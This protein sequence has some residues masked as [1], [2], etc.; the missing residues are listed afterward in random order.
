VYAYGKP[1][2]DRTHEI[3]VFG[4]WQIPKIEVGLNAYYRYMSGRTWTAFQ[5]FSGSAINWPGFGS[6]GRQPWL[7][8]RGSRRL[9]AESY[10][11]LRLEKI[12]NLGAGTDRIAVYADVQNLL[13]A[14][15][16]IATNGRY[17]EVSIGG[18]DEPIAFGDPTTIIGPRRWLL[19]ARWSCTA[20]SPRSRRAARGVTPRRRPP[21]LF[22]SDSVSPVARRLS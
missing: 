15:T 5:R 16:I 3:K 20:R 21:S 4:T 10:L 22:P 12:F 13:N 2:N 9:D 17:P 18:Y 1:V 11:D 8:P 6:Q 19:G 14:G 7:E